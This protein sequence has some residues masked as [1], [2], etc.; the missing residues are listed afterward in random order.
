MDI[1]YST[2]SAMCHFSTDCIDENY[3]LNINLNIFLVVF[4]RN[5]EKRDGVL[6]E[7]LHDREQKF[8]K[9]TKYEILSTQ[10][11]KK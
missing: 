1:M 7:N 9:Y 8:L 6:I 5:Y 4:I 3:F 2:V 10:F 11:T